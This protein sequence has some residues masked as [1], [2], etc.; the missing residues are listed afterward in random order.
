MK[1]RPRG[2]RGASH[3]RRCQRRPSP[4]NAT[5]IWSAAAAWP[6]DERHGVVDADHQSFA[7]PNLYIVDGSVLPT[8][9]SA[10]PA[11]TIMALA[12]RCADRDAARCAEGI[13]GPVRRGP[14]TITEL[15]DQCLHHPHRSPRGRRDAQSGTRPRWS[16]SRSA[17]GI[18]T[19][20]G[21]TY[22]GTGAVRVIEDH[23]ASVVVGSEAVDLP[24][25]GWGH[26]PG[27]YGTWDDPASS[28]APSR[29]ST[30][31]CGT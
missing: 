3:G 31:P 13:G 16:S 28:P 15:S 10:N 29:R 7:V 24:R 30:S 26:G 21:W 23:L 22:A 20:I 4:S 18:M 25:H 2:P 17:T 27:R 11:L 14:M 6:H 9:G 1:A 8:Q 12:A 5:P 19:G